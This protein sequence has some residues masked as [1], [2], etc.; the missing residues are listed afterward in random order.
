MGQYLV[1][2][3]TTAQ[4]KRG[5]DYLRMQL[6]EPGGKVWKAVMWDSKEV[7]QGAV[8]DALVEEDSFGG[9]PQLNVKALRVLA[10]K[11]EGD[12]FLPRATMDVGTLYEELK[13]WVSTITDPKVQAVAHRAIQDP[14]WLRGPAAQT[15][16]HAFLGGLLEHTVNLCRLGDAVTKLYPF[17]RRDLLIFTAVI[18]DVGKLDEMTCETNIEYTTEGKLCGHIIQGFERLLWWLA[19]ENVDADTALLLKHMLLSH[20]GT[21]AFGSP[22]SP[23]LLEAQ[24]FSNLDGLDAN[25][26]GM[27]AAIKRAE[28]KAWTDK[29]NTGQALYLGEVKK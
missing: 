13:T 25:L 21:Q 19:E 18:H 10:D 23:Q 2:S 1:Q 14:R 12:T 27:T 22:K 9:E 4:T 16:H 6:V 3:V 20:H 24:V 11:P 29:T 5:K 15:M 17:L 8:I 7:P 26:G 28:G